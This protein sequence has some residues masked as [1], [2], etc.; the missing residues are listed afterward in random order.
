MNNIKGEIYNMPRNVLIP[1][2]EPNRIRA[3]CYRGAGQNPSIYY[4]KDEKEL[5]KLTKD[6]P[7]FKCTI[8]YVPLHRAK[9]YEFEN[10]TKPADSDRTISP[11]VGDYYL[12]PIGKDDG[13]V[14]SA[15]LYVVENVPTPLMNK[16]DLGTHINCYLVKLNTRPANMEQ[17]IYNTYHLTI[18]AL[19]DDGVET[20][21]VA[22]VFFTSLQI[23][24]YAGPDDIANIIHK[25]AE[26]F[27][28]MFD[29]KAVCKD[30]VKELDK[31]EEESHCHCEE[32]KHEN[33][34]D[35]DHA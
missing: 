33:L 25:Y 9:I 18:S 34:L 12:G 3:T 27:C 6:V 11:A 8:E 13:F 32:C 23:G 22:S 20:Y 17:S 24:Q 21:M 29:I 7:D 19:N 31:K 1:K 26:A 15:E 2:G 4:F 5:R 16:Y 14:Y 10:V 35:E 30:I 28:T